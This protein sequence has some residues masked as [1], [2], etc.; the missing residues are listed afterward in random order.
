[1]SYNRYINNFPNESEFTKY[2]GGSLADVPNTALIDDTGEMKYT[3]S[4]VDYY[5]MYGTISGTTDDF[6]LGKSAE[7]DGPS[8]N[9]C[10]Q[11]HVVAKPDGINE[12]YAKQEDVLKTPTN[13][14]YT[15]GFAY[16]KIISISKWEISTKWVT[17]MCKMFAGCSSLASLNVSKFD[18]SL[19]LNMEGLFQGCSELTSLDVSSF[20]TG[21]VQNMD[22]MFSGCSKLTSLDVSNF[23]TLNVT[24][25]ERMFA[26]CERLQY[27]DLNNFDTHIVTNMN[28]MFANCGAMYQLNIQNF[29]T[30][31]VTTMDDIF[32]GCNNIQFLNVGDKFFNSK[33]IQLYDFSG[34]INWVDSQTI[35]NFISA[36]PDARGRR[37]DFSEY[38]KNA[39]TEDQKNR[40]N[41]KGW[42]Y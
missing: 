38:T 15:A 1:M 2:I 17:T 14:F 34:L 32:T 13:F 40:I 5:V 36:L 42:F 22:R 27:L 8:H 24:N 3:K 16:D 20:D 12:M 4:F 11:V 21:N 35:D 7:A 10:I 26:D 31:N 29:D 30:S 37:L 6:M 39:M 9:D 19:V 25:M 33:T 23:N 28:S 41:S 18:T